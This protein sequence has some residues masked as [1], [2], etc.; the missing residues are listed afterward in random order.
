MVIGSGSGMHLEGTVLSFILASLCT[1]TRSLLQIK[2]TQASDDKNCVCVCSHRHVSCGYTDV[3]V[4]LKNP[5]QL[6][7]SIGNST[8]R[9]GTVMPDKSFLCGGNRLHSNAHLTPG[10]LCLYHEERKSKS[11]LA[12]EHC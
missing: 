9:S 10:P 3:V 4:F 11:V 6:V 7:T 5:F 1:Q 8:E 2:I 12:L